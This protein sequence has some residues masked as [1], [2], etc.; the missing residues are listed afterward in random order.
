[1]R[2]FLVQAVLRTTWGKS[3]SEHKIVAA[4]DVICAARECFDSLSDSQKKPGV[5]YPEFFKVWP[6]TSPETFMSEV[7]ALEIED[8]F[9]EDST[10]AFDQI[11]DMFDKHVEVR[12]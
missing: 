11:F 7:G 8:E 10:T 9:D 6:M 12:L 3:K 1:M 2:F 5:R 4:K